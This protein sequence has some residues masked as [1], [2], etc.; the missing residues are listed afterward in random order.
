MGRYDYICSVCGTESEF[1]RTMAE[2]TEPIECPSCRGS[3]T[4]KPVPETPPAV[5]CRGKSKNAPSHTQ[6]PSTMPLL[7]FP[8]RGSINVAYSAGVTIEDSNI[9]GTGDVGIHLISSRDCAVK[10]ST[11]DNNFKTPILDEG[12]GRNVIRGNVIS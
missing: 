11:I 2:C 10:D 9:R 4:L 3:A 7:P 5:V 1:E 6:Q 12:K 8:G